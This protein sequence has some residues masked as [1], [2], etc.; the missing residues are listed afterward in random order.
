MKDKELEDIIEEINNV[1][2]DLVKE[3]AS[4]SGKFVPEEERTKL[5]EKEIRSP[6]KDD[7]SQAPF[8]VTD[9]EMEYLFKVQD[10]IKSTL[11]KAI[12]IGFLTSLIFLKVWTQSGLMKDGLNQKPLQ[13]I[14]I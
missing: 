7:T 14:P 4:G 2:K 10:E 6:F 1:A 12:I 8:K 9:E 11:L 3:Y 13:L 5:N